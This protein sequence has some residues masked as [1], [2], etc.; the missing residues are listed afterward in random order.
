[1]FDVVHG[2]LLK[3]VQ[4]SADGVVTVWLEKAADVDRVLQ[5]A[6]IGERVM[7][8]RYTKITTGE[9][10]SYD[11]EPYS[12]RTEHTRVG[13]RRMLYA[14]DVNEGTIKK[15]VFAN[16]SDADFDPDRKYTPRWEVEI[17][18]VPTRRR[19]LSA[20]ARRR[21]E[22]RRN[23]AFAQLATQ[24][25]PPTFSWGAPAVAAPKVPTV[26]APSKP[27][28]KPAA[29]PVAPKP[30]A[31]RAPVVSVV[32][33][34]KKEEE[35][36]KKKSSKRKPVGRPAKKVRKD[37]K[38][39]DSRGLL[40][41][42]LEVFSENVSKD[43]K[44]IA[45]IETGDM[46]N[47][48]LYVWQKEGELASEA[49]HR[50]AKKFLDQASKDNRRV[51]RRRNELLG[52]KLQRHAEEL[53]AKEPKQEEKALT[54]QV[55]GDLRRLALEKEGEKP[56][57]GVGERTGSPGHYKYKYVN[58]KDEHKNAPIT[59]EHK[60]AVEGIAAAKPK[61]DLGASVAAGFFGLGSGEKERW[62]NAA[63]EL[64]NKETTA[65]GAAGLARSLK[66]KDGENVA[67]KRAQHLHG[68]EMAEAGHPFGKAYKITNE[69]VPGGSTMSIKH[70]KV[71]GA[72]LHYSVPKSGG[73]DPTIHAKQLSGKLRAAGVDA[74]VFEEKGKVRVESG[75]GPSGWK[76][77]KS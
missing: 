75:Y 19:E 5:I 60:K 57:E 69:H 3:D 44:L 37:M 52:L 55:F 11:V 70:D 48:V 50:A 74:N 31:G 76:E 59:E 42:G 22:A 32:S 56:Y 30:P 53:A 23:A 54:S 36:R 63:R 39:A 17:A 64:S 33:R 15:F 77:Q 10:K 28:A 18:A 7:T 38:N 26:P 49:Y 71:F 34:R 65:V 51:H 73:M 72:S 58:V 12:F 16:I 35:E 21:Q 45:R 6:A 29:K 46:S 40:V 24:I 43:S 67:W 27:V 9:T 66:G 41:K 47:P 8:I 2:L 20:E 25:G 68:M 4:E 13:V 61:A 1:M 14:Y 62:E